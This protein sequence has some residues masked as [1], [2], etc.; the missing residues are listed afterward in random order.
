[1][2]AVHSEDL[3]VQL[4]RHHYSLGVVAA[5][6]GLVLQAGMALRRAPS[7]LAM[8]WRWGGIEAGAPSFS[9]VRLWLL[10]LGLYQLNRPKEQADDWMWIVDHTLQIG[11]HKCMI[12]VGIRQSAWEQLDSRVLRQED[13]EVIDL[14]PVRESNGKV[15]H[16]QL[17]A[18]TAKTGVPRAIISDDG[19]DLHA[20]IGLFC[21]KHPGTVWLYDIKH[22]TACLLKRALEGDASWGVFVGRVHRFKQQ[23]SQTDLAGL[24]PPQQRSKARY[25]NVDVLLK[26]A[27]KHLKLLDS[28]K[29]M[30][31]AGLKPADVERK[32]GW[33]RKYATQIRRWADMLALVEATE[34]YVRHEGIHCEAATELAAALPQ[35]MSAKAR[36]LR[37]Q[38]LDFVEE[39]AQQ[40]HEGEHLLG[41]SEVLESIIG[42]YKYVAGERGAHGMTGMVLSVGA[43]VGHYG[44]ETVQAA[45]DS[46]KNRDVWEWCRSKLGSTVQSMR[47]RVTAALGSEQKRQP[48]LSKNG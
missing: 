43:S 24:A 44:V 29:I 3:A 27:E 22:K 13:V 11:E 17:E 9:S 8:S 46:V 4:P 40:A 34:H 37:R 28:P 42:R 35:P 20:G 14:Q 1:L 33:L 6:L 19:S 10:R 16:R 38:L 5:S 7:V 36:Q 15:V 41:S 32:L 21:R 26:W 39:E 25:M 30:R 23:V 45:L 18:A 12:L 31:A 48:L 47:R 2:T